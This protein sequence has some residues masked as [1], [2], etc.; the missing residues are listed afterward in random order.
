MVDWQ[1][2]ALF[3]AALATL[4]TAI[5][6]A[7]VTVLVAVRTTNRKIDAV[8]AKV[9]GVQNEVKTMNE[10]TIGQLAASIETVRIETKEAAGKSLTTKE[11]RHLEAD[12]AANGGSL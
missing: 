5:A 2:L 4:I 9:D 8:E 1:G 7:T 10:S 3:T 6:G 12:P 11:Q